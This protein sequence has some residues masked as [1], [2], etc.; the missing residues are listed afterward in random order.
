MGE[1]KPDVTR[2]ESCQV[3]VHGQAGLGFRAVAR[4]LHCDLKPAKK[5]PIGSGITGLP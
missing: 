2:K 3:E 4:E 5:S 1:K